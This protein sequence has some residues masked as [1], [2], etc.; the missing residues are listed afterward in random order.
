MRT[1]LIKR[2][3]TL[4]TK[5]ETVNFLGCEVSIFLI[6]KCTNRYHLDYA[7]IGNNIR[8]K[9]LDLINFSKLM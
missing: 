5:K 3:N 1:T 9:L 7:K 2:P 6:W 4:L 8:Y